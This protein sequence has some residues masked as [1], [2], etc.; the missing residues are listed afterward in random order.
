MSESPNRVVPAALSLVLPG[1][2]HAFLGRA[3]TGLVFLASIGLLFATGL[4]MDGEFF[5]VRGAAPLT[6]LAGLAEMG[7]GLPYFLARALGFGAG[8]PA[9]PTYEYGYAFLIS[10]GLLNLLV[11]LHASDLADRTPPEA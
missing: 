2:G 5:P 11:A 8:N 3:R 6:L 10:A 4:A 1:L 7:M 9:A